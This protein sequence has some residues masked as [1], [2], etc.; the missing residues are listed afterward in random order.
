MHLSLLSRVLLLIFHLFLLTTTLP[1]ARYVDVPLVRLTSP[2][3][4][5]PISIIILSFYLSPMASSLPLPPPPFTNKP[6]L[7]IQVEQ[8]EREPS[9]DIPT[10]TTDLKRSDA[11][12]QPTEGSAERPLLGRSGSRV[13]QGILRRLGR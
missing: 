12:Q 9:P 10:T 5:P 6:H 8:P 4:P 11:Q 7:P 2:L 1:N 3:L 13:V